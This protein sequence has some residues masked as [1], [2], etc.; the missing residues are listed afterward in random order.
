M[1]RPANAVGVAGLGLFIALILSNL[2]VATEQKTQ[3][4]AFSLQEASR[5]LKQSFSGTKSVSLEGISQ[6]IGFIVDKKTQEVI[7]LG[8]S[9]DSL[10]SLSLDDLISLMRCAQTGGLS[11]PGVSLEPQKSDMTSDQLDV[12]FFG[13]A[14]DTSLGRACFESD[15]LMKKI[16]ID[17][18]PSGVPELETYAQLTKK[19]FQQE[20]V[21]TWNVLS[22]FWF[23]PLY[24][25]VV[26]TNEEDM[27]LLRE[28][29][30]GVMV[31]TISAEIDN[32]PMSTFEDEP[33]HKYASQFTQHY[34]DVAKAHPEFADLERFMGGLKLMSILLSRAPSESLKFWLQE[35]H[36]SQ[37]ETPTEVPLI[38]D[39]SAQGYRQLTLV[40][41]VRIAGLTMRLR[42]GEISAL[43]DAIL[44]ARP[45]EHSLTWNVVLDQDWLVTIPSA[46]EKD[47]KIAKLFA[48]ALIQQEKGD[49]A[50]AI[51]LLGEVV[52]AY[53]DVAE[54]RFLRAVCSRN[55]AVK[56]GKPQDALQPLEELRGLGR[57]YPQFVEITY[58]V[59][60]TLRI[61]GRVDEAIEVLEKVVKVRPDFAP[62]HH[63]LGLAYLSKGA[64]DLAK[65][66]LH[67]YLRLSVSSDSK[68][69]Q[70]TK[71]L[72][73]EID[74]SSQSSSMEVNETKVFTD[75]E[76]HFQCQYPK[77]WKVLR[78]KEVR[79]LLPGMKEAQNVAVAFMDPVKHDNNV[80]IQVVP[81]EA[82]A[83]SD[84]DIQDAIPELDAAY[85]TRFKNFEKIKSDSVEISN[86]KGIRYVFK[87]ERAGVSIQQCVITL[88]K[89][90]KAYTLT[91]TAQ[92]ADYAV[93]WDT[94]ASKILKEFRILE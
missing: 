84:Q 56:N 46:S 53:P 50:G 38:K 31:Q 30:V 4:V 79:E 32:K 69:V 2:V 28:T 77:S 52:K 20:K 80:N 92:E 58:E 81:I 8:K 70:D 6:L 45:S 37:V 54:A 55:A 24:T 39:I 5:S 64:K 15:Y 41:G 75:E 17:K 66:H 16:A 82:D 63:A 51:V 27:F 93:V 73:E 74:T 12:I 61:L 89:N 33:A 60:T 44:L 94:C 13:G 18:I 67:T 10:S 47:N 42:R 1:K 11:G 48:D 29:Q 22:R 88:V 83:L 36:T 85:A 57:E 59:G 14:K 86:V 49:D 65:E 43:R 87:C 90:R 62:A 19:R 26:T 9:S 72:L 35:Y 76:N 25:P 91:Y 21:A 23:A 7:I 34:N 3:I 68:Y 71:R 78:T 40:G